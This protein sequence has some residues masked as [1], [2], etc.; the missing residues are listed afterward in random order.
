MS[1]ELYALLTGLNNAFRLPMDPDP[2]A[3]Y[4]WSVAP[5]E[6]PDLTPVS[7]TMQATIDMQFARQKHYFLSLQNIEHVCFTAL[8]T[9]INNGFKVSTDPAIQ[10]WHAGMTVQEI[11]DQLSSIYGLPML[12][13]ME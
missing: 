2:N 10:G 5:G 1:R 9:S 6:V 4:T 8:N 7:R 12:A 3:N 13:A 11:L